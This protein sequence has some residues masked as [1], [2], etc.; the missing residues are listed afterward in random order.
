MTVPV[1]TGAGCIDRP[2]RS[3]IRIRWWIFGYMFGFYLRE[4]K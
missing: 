4:C 3:P 2:A 1:G